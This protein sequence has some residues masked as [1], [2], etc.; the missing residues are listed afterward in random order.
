MNSLFEKS[1]D[2]LK[3]K[4]AIFVLCD[5]Y[6]SWNWGM[7]TNPIIFNYNE[8]LMLRQYVLEKFQFD[9]ENSICTGSGYDCI[10][11]SNI[12]SF[13]GKR[14]CQIFYM[15]LSEDKVISEEDWNSFFFKNELEM[16][17]SYN[18]KKTILSA[19]KNG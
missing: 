13:L 7:P 10:V 12:E 11:P 3:R 17:L 19:I 5:G 8:Y 14:V 9:I 16:R 18:R 6:N 2:K 1:I 4:I 15:A